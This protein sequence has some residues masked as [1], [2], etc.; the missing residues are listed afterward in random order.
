MSE[1]QIRRHRNGDQDASDNEHDQQLD[2]RE[3]LLP[4]RPS[5]S[6]VAVR[7]KSP[8]QHHGPLS[9]LR[10][11]ALRGEWVKRR[12]SIA[13]LTD[14]D[15]RTPV[16]ETHVTQHRRILV[17]SADPVALTTA[18]TLAR[19]IDNDEPIVAIK[20]DER[21]V[22]VSVLEDLL[23]ELA[24]TTKCRCS[25]PSRPTQHL[26]GSEDDRDQRRHDQRP[27]RP[28]SSIDCLRSK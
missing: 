16:D 20:H 9:A 3:A 2:Q 23:D 24:V 19:A 18:Q 10:P 5:H 7:H 12:D 4:A 14:V 25:R 13:S 22:I 28:H 15:L 11:E 8:K 26:A 17:V 6:C 21:D 1:T 27:T